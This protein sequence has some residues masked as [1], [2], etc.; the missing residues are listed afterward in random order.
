MFWALTL[1]SSRGA[2][3][4]EVGY[5]QNSAKKELEILQVT[6]KSN[7]NSINRW[8]A[9]PSNFWRKTDDLSRIFR[10]LFTRCYEAI[11]EFR[12]QECEENARN[13]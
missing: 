5:F 4:Q 1:C 13:G 11:A 2:K 7:A 8:N 6:I 10:W 3:T 9:S 12:L